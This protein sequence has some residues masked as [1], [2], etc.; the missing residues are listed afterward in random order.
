[1]V[2]AGA[3][4]IDIERPVFADGD[5][6]QIRDEGEQEAGSEGRGQRSGLEMVHG[7]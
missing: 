3:G 7:L 1:M 6:A 4:N 2:D 5:T